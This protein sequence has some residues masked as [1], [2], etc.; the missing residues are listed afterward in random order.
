ILPRLMP[1]V[2]VHFHDIF[3]P[4]EYPK[5]WVYQGRSWNE[6]YLLRAF[7]QYN[8][9]FAIEISNSFIEHFHRD[10]VSRTMPLCL[11]YAKESM[12][13]TSAQSIWL[14]KLRRSDRGERLL[15][16]DSRCAG[17]EC[18]GTAKARFPGASML[19]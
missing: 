10:L 11:N 9:A 2:V 8:D 17:T 12:I 15:Q 18:A 13:P 3:H 16:A 5:P 19:S 14:K 1:G 6:A 7:L 4:F